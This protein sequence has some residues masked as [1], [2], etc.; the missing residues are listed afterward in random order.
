MATKTTKQGLEQY[1][2]TNLHPACAAYRAGEGSKAA[3]VR[4]AKAIAR[5]KWELTM[6]A[7]RAAG[8]NTFA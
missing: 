4:A 5:R 8:E 7:R 2:A 6:A 1:N 3:A